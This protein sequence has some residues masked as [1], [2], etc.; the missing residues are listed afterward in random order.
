MKAAL[1]KNPASATDSETVA[2]SAVSTTACASRRFGVQQSIDG[3]DGT[4]TVL[5]S[6]PTMMVLAV[7]SV[8]MMLVQICL[9]TQTAETIVIIVVMATLH[10]TQSQTVTLASHCHCES[11]SGS[12]GNFFQ[13]Y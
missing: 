1:A 7:G 4:G 2:L 13:W 5:V 6:S 10:S 8:T 11:L 9:V 3:F 12:V